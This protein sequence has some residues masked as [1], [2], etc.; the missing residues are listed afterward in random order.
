[1]NRFIGSFADGSWHAVGTSF[2]LRCGVW[3]R[4]GGGMRGGAG[5]GGGGGGV[6]AGCYS[7]G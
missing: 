5:R 2:D 3:G 6:H 1:M 7:S 4:G